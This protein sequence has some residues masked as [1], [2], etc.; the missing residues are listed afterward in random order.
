MP[1]LEKT[2]MTDLRSQ[3][4]QIADQFVSEM[5]DAMRSATLGD[6]GAGHAQP[7]RGRAATAKARSRGASTVASNA[8]GKRRRRASPDEVQKLKEMA[9]SAA[10]ALKSDFSKGD[11]MKRSGSKVDL[12]RALTLLVA[13]GKLSKKGDRRLTRYTVK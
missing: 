7:A 12:G 8:S 13:D 11:V 1:S 2:T 4:S 9:L 5:L 3:L 6:F 10:K